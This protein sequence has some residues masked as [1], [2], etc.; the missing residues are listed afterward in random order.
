MINS[1]EK[2]RTQIRANEL[3]ALF[4]IENNLIFEA[5]KMLVSNMNSG[6]DSPMTFDLLIRIY[7]KTCNYPLLLST[8]DSGIKRT[9]KKDFYR[10]LKKQIIF[11]R[12]LKDISAITA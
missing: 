6:T 2:I 10:R 1:V 8:L 5:E 4:F 12:L 3:K 7:E 9:V 11:S